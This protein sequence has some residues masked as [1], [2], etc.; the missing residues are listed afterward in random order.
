MVGLLYLQVNI[1]IQHI[2]TDKHTTYTY[3]FVYNV[4]LRIC[5]Q[6]IKTYT[7]G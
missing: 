1:Y 7:Y 3:G 6:H 5:N 4:Y 2:L